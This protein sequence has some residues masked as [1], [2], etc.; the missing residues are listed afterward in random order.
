MTR[1]RLA[2]SLIVLATVTISCNKMGG[3]GGDA[4]SADGRIQLHLPSGWREAEI[5]GSIGKIQAKSGADKDAFVSVISEPKADLHH[6]SIQDYA[7]SILAIEAGKGKLANRTV[8]EPKNLKIGECPAVQYEVRGTVGHTNIVY[9]K[10]FVETATRWNQVL[11]WT[12][13][14]HLDD[15]RADFQAIDESFK[16]LPA[17]SK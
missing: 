16:E 17:G 4:K 15:V 11:C 8:S 13:P 9:V 6:D 5:Q 1:C 14:S 7:H 3:S 12:T 2:M 10:T